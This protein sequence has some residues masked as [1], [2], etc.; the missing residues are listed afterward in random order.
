M[1]F[2]LHLTAEIDRNV[3]AALIED[4]GSGD[5][6][7]MLTP[8]GHQSS[9]TVISRQ[10]AVLA[11][12]A[13]FD[14]CF[15]QLDAEA[16]IVWHA[17]DGQ[18]IAVGQTLC[19]IQAGTRP[20]LTAERAALNFLQLLSG[21]AT[22]TRR[23]VDAV[24]GTGARIV[25]TRKTL[26]GLRLAQKYA[27]RCGGGANHR[28]GLDDAVLI[29]DNHLVVAGGVAAAVERARRHVGHL[30]KSEVEVETIA[31]RDEA[32]AL[33]VDAVLLDNFDVA[34]LRGAVVRVAGR[35]VT[36]ASGGITL[37]TAR[38]I[39]ETGVDLLSVGALTHSAP[40]LDVALDF[41]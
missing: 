38:R 1:D 24:A 10:D 25:D 31:Q 36:E 35:C 11:G 14:A 3:A 18:R 23:Y 22:T 9:G 32:L 40:A 29:K 21:V 33:G 28:F 20:L 41:D 30:G 8:G 17:N 5:L 6:T 7:A 37:A 4:I 16:E 19:E 34:A 12:Q 39:A 15:Q 2:A 13:W 26:P 27:V